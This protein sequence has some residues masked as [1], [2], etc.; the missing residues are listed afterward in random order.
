M[1]QLPHSMTPGM[2]G[3]LPPGAGPDF[4]AT[5]Q[6]VNIVKLVHHLFR[7][8][9]LLAVILAS[10]GLVTGVVGGWFM[11][12]P[13]YRAEA[14]INIRPERLNVMRDNEMISM[15]N[16]YVNSQISQLL[17][18]RVRAKAMNSSAWQ[19]LGL[20]KGP[21]ADKDFAD[22][23]D[24][25]YVTAN[26]PDRLR[27]TFTHIDPTVAFTGASEVCKAYQELV[28]DMQ[29]Q[30]KV[31][32]R[33]SIIQA[34]RRDLEQKI[35]TAQE[36]IK[37]LAIDLGTSDARAIENF[38][39]NK[40]IELR[41]AI[42]AID[43]VLAQRGVTPPTPPPATAVDAPTTPTTLASD[44]NGQSDAASDPEAAPER[45]PEEL[46]Y[47]EI[48]AG[49]AKM[50][51]LLD[52]KLAA[53][54]NL[55]KW[56]KQGYGDG[57]RF[58][59]QVLQQI[60]GIDES[61]ERRRQE[62]LKSGAALANVTPGA[63]M[64]TAGTETT[65]SLLRQ[66]ANLF[67]QL[68][69][70]F[71]EAS[72]LAGKIQEM[73]TLKRSIED[74]RIRVG[75]FTK[76]LEDIRANAD[77]AARTGN[78]TIEQPP[79][80]PGLP[81]NSARKKLA[82]AFGFVGFVLPLAVIA[83]Y[84][85]IDRRYRYSDE[86]LEEGPGNAPLLGVLPKLPSDLSD[87]EQAAAAAHCVHQIR[88]LIQIGGRKKRV[89]AVT[90]SNPGD[91]KTSLALSLGF[92]FAGSGAKTLLVDLDMIGQGL[93]RGLRMREPTSF[94]NDILE[95]KILERVKR[96]NVSNLWLMPTG[97]ADDHRTANR[98]SEGM[99]SKVLEAVRDDYD[100]V[101][102]DTG[103]VLG[104]IEAHLVCAQADGVVLVVGAGRARGQVKSAVEQLHRVG[105]SVLGMVF[106]LAEGRDFKTSAA[107]QSFR[108][109]R[110][111]G[112]PPER[113]APNEYPELEPLPRVVA[114]DTKR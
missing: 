90:S 89:F 93:S 23:L 110:P 44:T 85:L 16:T 21:S 18:P 102:I 25:R 30:N 24:V 59:R 112:T 105:A 13:V 67:R 3:A 15:F 94:F 12:R 29:D 43:S 26:T 104:S 82:L 63:A 20:E 106:N 53:L 39:V 77:F 71:K 37:A 9:Y 66:R 113:P 87:T 51:D 32:A 80:A 56:R 108:S 50:A 48:A 92:S 68:N 99:V 73:D 72:V 2:A 1:T 114:L 69:D 79:E 101:L 96:T 11:K 8:R 65:A 103:P 46:S 81:D 70:T 28:V 52:E 111:D 45:K 61:M 47:E 7:G 75:E 98:L 40:Q 49:D 31:A 64:A 100:I 4:G 84:G 35:T 17:S 58:V 42:T 57:H 34:Q 55:D 86:A 41:T 27:L 14:Y 83:L 19:N 62:W 22:A 91:G 95:G 88:T 97:V 74:S 60:E 76:V 6:Q 33:E 78:I 38:L 107:S 10:L 5:H 109:V 54:N 36:R